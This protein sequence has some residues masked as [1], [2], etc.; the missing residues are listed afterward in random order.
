MA[1]RVEFQDH[2]LQRVGDVDIVM[3]VYH[4]AQWGLQNDAPVAL[5]PGDLF[6]RLVHDE[7][8]GALRGSEDDP[9]ARIGGDACRFLEPFREVRVGIPDHLVDP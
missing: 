6:L 3:G 7:N 1:V 8:H 5:Q 9:P 4:H 2:V